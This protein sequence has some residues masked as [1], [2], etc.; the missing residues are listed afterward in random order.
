MMDYIYYDVRCE[1]QLRREYGHETDGFLKRQRIALSLAFG[2]AQM[3]LSRAG[4][5]KELRCT[6]YV[7]T[8]IPC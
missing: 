5:G 4:G 2:A 8:S 7:E 3:Y 1:R 6:A